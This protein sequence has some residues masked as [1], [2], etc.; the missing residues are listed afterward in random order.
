MIWERCA[1]L[2]RKTERWDFPAVYWSG[3]ISAPRQSKIPAETACLRVMCKSPTAT[4]HCYMTMHKYDV[5]C[6]MRNAYDVQQQMTRISNT[7]APESRSA[8]IL[9][10]AVLRRMPSVIVISKVLRK[11][12]ISSTREIR[13]YRTCTTRL[14][15]VIAIGIRTWFRHSRLRST[16]PQRNEPHRGTTAGRNGRPRGLPAPASSNMYIY[17]SAAPC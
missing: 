8:Q 15:G 7:A 1:G 6:S 11:C 2:T 17:D 16:T 13:D 10:I 3:L 12:S 5:H 9:L 4:F 14:S